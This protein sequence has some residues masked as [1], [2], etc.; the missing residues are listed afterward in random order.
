MAAD[1]AP[2]ERHWNCR[3]TTTGRRSGKPRT[4]TIWFALDPDPARPRVFLT[5]GGEAPQWCRNLR[6]HPAVEVQIGSTRLRGRARVAGDPAEAEAVRQRFVRRYLLARLAR[7][8]GRGYVDSTAV[9]V[10]DLG[11]A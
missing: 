9:V 2:L 11:P 7:A 8:L 5:G 1:L 10:E 4:V 6:A 3:L